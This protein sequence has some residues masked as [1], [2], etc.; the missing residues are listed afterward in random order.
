[1]E[2]EISSNLKKSNYRERN[3]SLMPFFDCFEDWKLLNFL[4]YADAVKSLGNV[5]ETHRKYRIILEGIIA[6]ENEIGIKR[7]KA[8]KARVKYL[9]ES[10]K[11]RLVESDNPAIELNE[12]RSNNIKEFWHKK[13]KRSL[14]D[15]SAMKTT[16]KIVKKISKMQDI[17]NDVLAQTIENNL[18]RQQSDSSDRDNDNN[19]EETTSKLPQ[20]I[21]TSRDQTLKSTCD[22]RSFDNTLYYEVTNSVAKKIKTS[23][24]D[25]VAGYDLENEDVEFEQDDEFG[26][27]DKNLFQQRF[28]ALENSR[29]WKLKSG[30]FVEDSC[31]L[32]IDPDDIFI[33]E[34]FTEE[35]ISEIVNRENEQDLPEIDDELFE[36]INTFARDS[37]KEIRK[38]L[39]ALHPRLGDNYNPQTDFIYDHIR[40]TVADWVRLFEMQPNPLT[41]DLPEAWY[42]INVWRTIDIAFSDIPYTYVVG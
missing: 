7:K 18:N 21:C 9:V 8:E 34:E 36:Y 39:N 32:I 26:V 16:R 20:K 41:L 15:K 38:A 31:P 19:N 12:I 30:R 24:E 42:R 28:D 17:T 29:K 23:S 4:K 14:I 13:D 37:T 22:K 10:N 11:E 3:E 27:K 2:S 1:M 25:E 5:T 40:T 35:E 6:D 33:K